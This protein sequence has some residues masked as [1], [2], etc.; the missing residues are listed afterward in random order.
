MPRD[1][2]GGSARGGEG[3][4]AIAQARAALP[5]NTRTGDV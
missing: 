3:Q 2:T 1:C 4:P 5:W